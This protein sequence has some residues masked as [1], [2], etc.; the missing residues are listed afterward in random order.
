[1]R[2]LLFA[3]VVTQAAI[4]SRSAAEP[5]AA[6]EEVRVRAK[7]LSERGRR[8]HDLGEYDRAIGAFREAYLLLP[9]PGVLFNLG[10]S[11]RL[12]GD[13]AAAAAAYRNFLQSDATDP[14]A[15]N[16][17]RSQLPIVERCARATP[18]PP[19]PRRGRFLRGGGLVTAIGGGLVLGAGMYFTVDS[20]RASDEVER[21]YENGGKWDDIA[22]TDARGR[23]SANLALAFGAGGGVAVATGA[24]LY[25]LGVRRGGATEPRVMVAPA[26][27]ATQVNV[28]W[29]F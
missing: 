23:R 9:S 10:Q 5:P 7:L 12:K 24:V 27:R 4:V 16:L 26:G 22:D 17:A 1:M 13:C 19:P 6:T 3:F 29:A 21:H 28:S 18:P 25:V 14:T 2:A 8:F 15:R 11:Y 20:Q